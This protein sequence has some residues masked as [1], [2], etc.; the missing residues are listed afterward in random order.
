MNQPLEL[1]AEAPA[2]CVENLR[3]EY[4]RRKGLFSYDL[5]DALS[6][7][8]FTLQR[9]D[10]LAVVGRNGAGKSTLL[11]V[12]AG[13]IRPSGGTIRNFQCSTALLSLQ[14]GFD[15]HLS[16]RDNAVL[17]GMFLGIPRNDITHRMNEIIEESQLGEF[18]D[19]PVRYYST[20]MRARLGF[21]VAVNLDPDV[22]LLDELLAVG[23]AEFREKSLEVMRNRLASDRTIVLVSHQTPTLRKLCNRAVWLDEGKTI[24][25]GNID[26]V[27]QR[28]ESNSTT[29]RSLRGV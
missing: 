19:Q 25:E 14:A 1:E 17:L 20:G 13:I 12:L 24:L 18:I 10:S 29:G 5:F 15:P 28:Y 7:V 26:E 8:S 11:R 23:D 4:R 16:G 27:L 2:I 6:D 21:S 9:G 3:V 22:L